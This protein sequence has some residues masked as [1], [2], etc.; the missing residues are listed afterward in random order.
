LSDAPGQLFVVSAPSGG[1]KTSLV[2]AV[3]GRVADLRVSVSHTTRACRAGEQDGLDYHFV[4]AEAFAHMVAEDAFLEHARVFDHHY[5]T[6]RAA[7]AAQLD[8][9]LDVILEIDWQ[10]AR[11][12]RQARPDTLSIFVLPP[13]IA[14]L[15]RR[16]ERRGDRPETIARRMQDAVR[17]MSH[18]AEYD[19]LVVNDDF[20]TACAA[21]AAIFTAARQRLA[22]QR[23]RHADMLAG[24]VA[25]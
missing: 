1:G 3:L 13:S 23:R 10:G 9:G 4:T 18:H 6:S 24:L 5:G 22:V 8:A 21:L 11:A 14:E 17:E 2:R 15:E 16:L 12:V 20:E 25:P 19:Y 7:L